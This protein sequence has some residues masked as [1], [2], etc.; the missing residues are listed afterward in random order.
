MIS[1]ALVLS[2]AAC[3][4]S[5]DGG[6]GSPGGSSED[7]LAPFAKFCRA[8]LKTEQKIEKPAGPGGW[9]GNGTKVPAGTTILLEYDFKLWGG[10]VMTNEGPQKIA[11]DFTK[12]LVKD[13][14][15][16]S[17]CAKEPDFGSRHLVVLAK[18]NVFADKSLTGSACVLQPGTDFSD[19]GFSSGGSGAPSQFQST[20]LKTICG[21]DQGYTNDLTYGNLVTR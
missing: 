18:S 19:Y 6:S 2:V 13:T 9:V 10:Y 21:F 7:A 5:S 3:S 1:L 8:T 15:F 16:T 17:D 12:G 14:D 4:S 20:Q 11:A